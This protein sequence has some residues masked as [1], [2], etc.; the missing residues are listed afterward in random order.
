MIDNNNKKK[1]TCAGVVP[2]VRDVQRDGAIKD[3]VSR[4]PIGSLVFPGC[5]CRRHDNR[6]RLGLRN[7]LRHEIHRSSARDRADIHFRHGIPGLPERRNLS[8]LGNLG[9][10]IYQLLISVCGYTYVYY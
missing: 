8:S 5:G 6:R 9:V 3:H 7:W 2:H 4:Y 10:S 1:K